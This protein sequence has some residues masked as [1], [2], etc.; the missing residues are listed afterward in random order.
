MLLLSLSKISGQTY[1]EDTGASVET[2]KPVQINSAAIRCF[3]ARNDAKPGSRITF[4]DGGGFAVLETPE[5]ITASLAA[6]G[7]N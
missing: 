7:A 2:T 4:V 6:D 3:Y 5:Q 1:D